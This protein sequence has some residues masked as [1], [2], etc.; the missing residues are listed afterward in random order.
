MPNV[1]LDCTG[2]IGLYLH[3]SLKEVEKMGTSRVPR[4]CLGLLMQGHIETFAQ[5]RFRIRSQARYIRT[6][7]CICPE[8]DQLHGTEYI[9]IYEHIYTYIYI[10]ISLYVC[11]YARIHNT[12]CTHIYVDVQLHI[13]ICVNKE[14]VHRHKT[15]SIIYISI[16][17][18]IRI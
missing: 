5:F 16:Y 9:Y 10:Y 1:C 4:G 15:Y 2:M 3:P 18:Y 17:T 14:N 12:I 7:H 6:K 13:H 8:A 11:M